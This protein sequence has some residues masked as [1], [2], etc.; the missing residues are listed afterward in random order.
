MRHSQRVWEDP[1]VDLVAEEDMADVVA[2]DTRIVAEDT[3]V[4]TTAEE[5]EVRS[6]LH[7]S[8]CFPFFNFH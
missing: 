8:V 1:E 5:E 2:E 6:T 4:D 3:M 7:H